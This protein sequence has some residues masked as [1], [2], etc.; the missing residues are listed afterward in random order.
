ML[1]VFSICI[2]QNCQLALKNCPKSTNDCYV[3]KHPVGI[4]AKEAFVAL[5]EN[6]RRDIFLRKYKKK[7]CY[8]GIS[9]YNS[10]DT[11]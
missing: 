1:H 9:R 11:Q 7:L 5:C 3:D 10:L 8:L 4:F 2:S 6:I